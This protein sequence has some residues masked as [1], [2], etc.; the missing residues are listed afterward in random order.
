MFIQ[1]QIFVSTSEA[2]EPTYGVASP[3]ECYNVF[4]V[5]HIMYTFA[6][7]AHSVCVD[8]LSV[9][10]HPQISCANWYAQASLGK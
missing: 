1:I 7:Y 3:S 6:Y 2:M 10:S 9:D 8:T 4:F 5:S